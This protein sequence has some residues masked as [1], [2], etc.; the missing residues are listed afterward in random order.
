[1]LRIYMPCRKRRHLLQATLINI[2][3]LDLDSIINYVSENTDFA[4]IAPDDPLVLG[5]TDRLLE[6]GIL[7]L[8]ILKKLQ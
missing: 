8:A 4:V 7:H 2:S 5:L 3:P 6:K 1:M